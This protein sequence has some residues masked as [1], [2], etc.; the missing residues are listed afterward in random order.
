MPGCLVPCYL[1]GSLCLEEGL[2]LG[3][4]LSFP[5][6]STSRSFCMGGFVW[7][8]C[9]GALWE[10]CLCLG[11]SVS[12]FRWRPSWQKPTL[13]Q[14]ETYIPQTETFAAARGLRSQYW[15]LVVATE[16]GGRHP[17]PGL[18]SCMLK[19]LKVNSL[20]SGENQFSPLEIISLVMIFT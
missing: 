17:T 6:D 4:S 18:H 16:A 5:W 14:T 20:N 7:G 13:P 8:L 12:L 9:L 19:C 1:G 15:H 2:C 11:V 3:K 10:T